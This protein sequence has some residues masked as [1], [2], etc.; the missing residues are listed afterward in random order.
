MIFNESNGEATTSGSSDFERSEYLVHV[1]WDKTAP[2]SQAI[3]EQGC[4][5]NQNTIAKPR[6]DTWRNNGATVEGTAG[7]PGVGTAHG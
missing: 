4:F 1:K 5:G 3:K 7:Y 2:G 6:G